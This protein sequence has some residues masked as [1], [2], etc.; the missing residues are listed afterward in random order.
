MAA[1]AKAHDAKFVMTVGDNFYQR[2]VKSTSDPYWTD[3]YEQVYAD[4]GLT[5]LPWFPAMGNHD[6]KGN[7][8]AQLDY[9][10]PT[11]RWRAGDNWQLNAKRAFYQPHLPP[12]VGSRLDVFVVDTT[13]VAEGRREEATFLPSQVGAHNQEEQL[14]WLRGAL[15]SS[16]ADWK[17]IFGHHCIYSGGDHGGYSQI[18]DWL[19]P[20]LTSGAANAY[21]CG[22]DHD[23]QHIQRDGIHYIVSGAGGDSR[24]TFSTTGTVFSKGRTDEDGDFFGFT[25]HRVGKDAMLVDYVDRQGTVLKTVAV[26]RVGAQLKARASA[27]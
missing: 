26:P 27:A 3:R 10:S 4:P 6:Y 1:W 21:V 20:L 18:E 12:A 5:P 9:T 16:K 24:A 14:N 8:Q 2:G 19:N 17:L 7:L 13:P 11:G 25:G 22:H 23:L 15:T